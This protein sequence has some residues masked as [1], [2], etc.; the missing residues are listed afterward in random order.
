MSHMAPMFFSFMVNKAMEGKLCLVLMLFIL[1]SLTVQGAIPRNQRK[2]PL[3]AFAKRLSRECFFIYRST[4]LLAA[5]LD[6][7]RD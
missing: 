6:I 4:S 5:W 2:N 1:G 7:V 3:A